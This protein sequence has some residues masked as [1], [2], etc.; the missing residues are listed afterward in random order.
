MG[1]IKLLNYE[2][3]GKEVPVVTVS[4]Q[5][6]VFL[7]SAYLV[8]KEYCTKGLGFLVSKRLCRIFNMLSFLSSLQRLDFFVYG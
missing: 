2:L 7:S 5:K 1:E 3:A 4:L 6:H 8:V